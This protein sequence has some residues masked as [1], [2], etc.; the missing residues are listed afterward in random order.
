[1]I[2]EGD[3]VDVM[4]EMPEA[5]VDS[6]VTDPP[7]GLEFMGKAW[8]KLGAG[9]RPVT[10][11]DLEA[12]GVRL[13]L[14]QRNPEK[15][16]AP[17]SMQAWHEAWAT[18]AL[19]L[20]KP[21]SYLLAFGGTRTFHRLAVALEDAG[22]V[23]RDCLVWAY[24]NGFPKS[25][26]TLKPAW[27]PIIMARKPGPLRDLAIDACRL[28]GPGYLEQA[29][30]IQGGDHF[31]VG[32]G[33]K[34][35]GTA[36]NPAQGGRFPANVMLTEPV[37]GDDFSRFYLIPK[38]AVSEREPTVG[39]VPEG[40]ARRNFHPTVKPVDLMR[41][42]V[43]LVTPIG[44]TVLDPFLGSGSTAIAAELEGFAWLGIE[45][46]PEYVEIARNRLASDVQRGLGLDVPY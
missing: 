8:D 26:A 20:S 33:L 13:R 7:Y 28:P 23:L 22:W 2:T 43:R 17:R 1:V 24:A 36:F 32:S 38:A 44:G 39:E 10:P 11:R 45:Q 16:I 5:S 29:G 37:L 3:C 15:L 4:R 6:I 18:E 42:L 12:G 14:R 9:F 41:H 25:K 34:T 31:S 30:K 46:S 19:R 21:G 27:E 40:A 35:R